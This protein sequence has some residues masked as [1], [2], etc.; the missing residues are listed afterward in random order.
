MS[1]KLNLIGLS[2]DRIA[3]ALARKRHDELIDIIAELATL[4]PHFSPRTVARARGLSQ[5]RIVAMCRSQTLRAHKPL[6]N[7][8][9]IPLSAIHEWDAQTAVAI[10]T[11]EDNG[12]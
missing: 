8:W 4:E 3:A 5:R 7:G 10:E 1:D 11:A 12:R 6:P 9:R 2:R